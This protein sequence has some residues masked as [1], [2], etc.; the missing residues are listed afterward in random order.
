MSVGLYKYEGNIYDENAKLVLSE[1]IA[2]QRFYEK[3]L[4]KGDK[5]IKHQIYARRGRN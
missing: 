4:G 2:S 5:G 1:N 3:V